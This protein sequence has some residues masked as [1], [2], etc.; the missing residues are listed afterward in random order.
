MSKQKGRPWRG[1]ERSGDAWR[2]YYLRTGV[3]QQFQ[4]HHHTIG[5]AE[6]AKKGLA[7]WVS[8]D[9]KWELPKELP[10]W[11]PSLQLPPFKVMGPHFSLFPL[12][13]G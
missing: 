11:E 7:C 10:G 13:S 6:T 9:A 8:L 2:N 1:L 5:K 4:L 12:P 3:F